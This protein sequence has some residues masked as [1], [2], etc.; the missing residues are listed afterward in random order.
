[1]A[2]IVGIFLALCVVLGA[3]MRPIV[4]RHVY[5]NGAD[6]VFVFE[7]PVYGAVAR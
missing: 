1:M 3:G 2:W 7:A 6:T 5:A 4:S